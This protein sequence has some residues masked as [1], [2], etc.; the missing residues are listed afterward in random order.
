MKK[1]A[2][3]VALMAAASTASADNYYLRVSS[4]GIKSAPVA[5]PALVAMS[6]SA[7]DFGKIAVGATAAK[8]VTLTNSGEVAAALS[9]GT[10]AA[11]FSLTGNQCSSML[12]PA[13]SCA[14]TVNYAPTGTA[15]D[16]AVLNVT[17]DQTPLTLTLD[18]MGNPPASSWTAL[19]LG[20]HNWYGLAFGNGR[21]VAFAND[22][23]NTST[24]GV[25]WNTVK[26]AGQSANINTMTYGA[27]KFV[28]LTNNSTA[29]QVATS[30]DGLNWTFSA[31][32]AAPWYGIAYGNGTFVAINAAQST[33]MTATAPDGV[34][35]TL[36]T[37][38]T[39]WK[40]VAF[41]GGKFVTSVWGAS[42]K[43]GVSTDGISWS[44]VT[45]PA[46]LDGSIS[47]ANGQFVLMGANYVLTS[48][49]AITWTVNTL[50]VTVGTSPSVS[51][52]NGKY[53]AVGYVGGVGGVALSSLDGRTWTQ[54]SIPAYTWTALT[55]GNGKFVASTYNGNYLGYSN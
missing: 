12:A 32:S 46:T 28:A 5:S 7:W 30:T 43:V 27:G 1:I 9:F 6:D 52:G 55:Y 41:G 48:S 14:F 37:A 38:A 54:V 2:S 23:I 53:M 17:Y 24:D 20:R 10:L 51:Y 42:N 39:R 15:G 13:G 8:T 25:T 3:L 21:F 26:P 50:P 22:Q 36:R 19:D 16:H 4:P 49:D 47:Y 40:N 11:P 33:P 44:T 29:G 45:I 18:G 34:T 31:I 35:W